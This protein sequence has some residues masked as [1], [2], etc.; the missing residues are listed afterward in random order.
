MLDQEETSEAGGGQ[1]DAEAAG[2]IELRAQVDREAGEK[3]KQATTRAADTARGGDAGGHAQEGGPV[4][5]PDV[6]EPLTEKAAADGKS[7]A[8]EC[9][10]TAAGQAPAAVRPRARDVGADADINS[11]EGADAGATEAK[12]EGDTGAQAQGKTPNWSKP[13]S[14]TEASEVIGVSTDNINDYLRDNPAAVKK[15][16]R[17]KW[18]FD[19]NFSM[20]CKLP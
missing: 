1:A 14:K 11:S 7:V 8:P 5:A 9:Q 17:Q 19:K 3:R 13:C 6:T 15:L 18:Q 10:E 4:K 20:F 12:Q 16:T 2:A